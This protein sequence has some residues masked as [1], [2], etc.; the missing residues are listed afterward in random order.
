MVGCAPGQH[1]RKFSAVLGDDGNAPPLM[2]N[3]HL[4]GW[5]GFD[6]KHLSKVSGL[7]NTALYA[8]GVHKGAE[9]AS[10]R[11]VPVS[12]PRM[13]GDENFL[14]F[15][16]GSQLYL[17]GAMV[18]DHIGE[19]KRLDIVEFRSV[20][21]WDSLVGFERTGEGQIVT[22]VLCRKASPDWQ[23]CHDALPAFHQ[24]KAAGPTGTPFPSSVKDYGFTFSPFY[25]MSGKLLKPLPK[26]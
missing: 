10:Y 24:I 6:E 23:K 1:T 22:R 20:S 17:V 2:R 21:S 12:S 16:P 5:V 25:D 3:K 11:Y 4:V 15:K 19:L 8:S 26:P 13:E 9:V 14:W 18:P 7:A